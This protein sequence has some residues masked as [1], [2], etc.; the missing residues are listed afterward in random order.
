[1]DFRKGGLYEASK[2]VGVLGDAW[3]RKCQKLGD[4]TEGA[5]PATAWPPLEQ[6]RWLVKHTKL[7]M[8]AKWLDLR[9]IRLDHL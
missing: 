2:V 5:H 4:E 6:R 9:V 1:M 3:S 8:I 7:Q